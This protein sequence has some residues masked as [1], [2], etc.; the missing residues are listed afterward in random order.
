MLNNL[1]VNNS[2]VIATVN[3]GS[4]RTI[5]LKVVNAATIPVTGLQSS[6]AESYGGQYISHIPM[7]AG[8]TLTQPVP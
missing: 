2:G 5:T 1:A 3:N 6:G 7:T 4:S 8:E